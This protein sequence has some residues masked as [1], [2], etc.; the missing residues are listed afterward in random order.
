MNG[1]RSDDDLER[2]CRQMEA[3]REAADADGADE[4]FSRMSEE[5]AEEMARRYEEEGRA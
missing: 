2:E 1:R 3:Q 4:M 5:E